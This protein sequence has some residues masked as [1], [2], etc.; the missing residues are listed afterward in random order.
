MAIT[1]IFSL[2]LCHRRRNGFTRVQPFVETGDQHADRRVASS[3]G[4]GMSGSSANGA[5][6]AARNRYHR[7]SDTGHEQR[8]EKHEVEQHFAGKQ[9]DDAEGT[10][11]TGTG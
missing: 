8:P 3:T 6:G 11:N 10:L 5:R 7:R 9:Q 2:A 1:S 4:A